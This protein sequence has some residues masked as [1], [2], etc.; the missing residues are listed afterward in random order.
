MIVRA[1]KGNSFVIL[2][3]QQYKPEIQ[4]FLHGNNFIASTTDPTNTVQKEISNT[5]KESKTLIPRDCKWKYINL[6]PS[7]P[8]IKGLIKLHKPGQL[9]RLVVN[10]RSALAYK[11]STLFM[12]KINSIAP[13]PNTFNIKDTTELLQNL[14]DTVMSPHY[15]FASY[16]SQTFTPTS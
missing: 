1:D 15:T 16:T 13:L 4:D 5:I 8:S 14:Q 11:L 2:P 3:T 7:A 10:W 12:Q 6:N 9:I